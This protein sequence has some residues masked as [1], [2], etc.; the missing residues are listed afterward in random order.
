MNVSQGRLKEKNCNLKQRGHFTTIGG[1]FHQAD[2]II[3]DVYKPN[4]SFKSH[5]EN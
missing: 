4:K 1:S 3:L 5:E 2:V